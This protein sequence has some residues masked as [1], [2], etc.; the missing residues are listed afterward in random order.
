[1]TPLFDWHI[2]FELVC[3]LIMSTGTIPLPALL[4]I[5]VTL[6]RFEAAVIIPVAANVLVIGDSIE[7]SQIGIIPKF[8]LAVFYS[9]W[10]PL[11]AVTDAIQVVPARGALCKLALVEGSREYPSCG[12][13]YKIS[14]IMLLSE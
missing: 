5:A 1:M 6:C 8:T 14:A 10:Y 4:S 7:A 2:A 13:E 9:D 3:P 12:L 11:L